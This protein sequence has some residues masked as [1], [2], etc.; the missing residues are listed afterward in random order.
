MLTVLEMAPDR[1]AWMAAIMRDPWGDRPI[2]HGTVEDRV[3]LG[4]QPRGVDDI[5]VFRDVFD[6]RLDGLGGVAE[7]AERLRHRVVDDLHRSAADEP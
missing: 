3:V 6:D 5:A 4:L 2:T 1:N 7:L